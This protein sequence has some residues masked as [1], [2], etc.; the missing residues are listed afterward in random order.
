MVQMEQIH[1]LLVDQEVILDAVKCDL[2]ADRNNLVDALLV[3]VIV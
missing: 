3:H 2:I 1:V